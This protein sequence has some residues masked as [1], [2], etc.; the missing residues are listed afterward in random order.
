ME[1]LKNETEDVL[2]RKAIKKI[3]IGY[4]DPSGKSLTSLIILHSKSP[5]K[6]TRLVLQMGYST[7]TPDK[8]GWTPLHHTGLYKIHTSYVKDGHVLL[9]LRISKTCPLAGFMEKYVEIHTKW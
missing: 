1:T 6:H 3:P 4:Q 2:F 9:A 7:T 5:L 8:N